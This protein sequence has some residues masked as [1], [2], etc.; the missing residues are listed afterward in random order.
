MFKLTNMISYI[1]LTVDSLIN[2]WAK[3]A[4]IIAAVSP[5]YISSTN[6]PKKNADNGNSVNRLKQQT[7]NNSFLGWENIFRKI[8][9]TYTIHKW[10]DK[11][12]RPNVI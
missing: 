3:A 7:A 8:N 1:L 6:D 10:Y 5:R 2:I 4:V 12:E 11:I 9:T